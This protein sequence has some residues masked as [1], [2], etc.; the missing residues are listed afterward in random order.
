MLAEEY[1]SLE[2]ENGTGSSNNKIV[3][4]CLDESPPAY[5]KIKENYLDEADAIEVPTD[6]AMM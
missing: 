2:L 4:D 5:E 1:E 6:E 3:Y